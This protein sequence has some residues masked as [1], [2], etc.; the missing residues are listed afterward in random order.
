MVT[1]REFLETLSAG[2]AGLAIASSARSYGQILGS[3]D[4]V[5][6]AVIGLN[7][8]AS[9]HLE[10]LIANKATSRIGHVCDVDSVILKRFADR[11]EPPA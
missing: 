6:F 5:N 2:T 3:N 4:R 10:S 9:A 8:R 1:R 11:A 7:G